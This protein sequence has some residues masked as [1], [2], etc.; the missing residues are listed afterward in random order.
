MV[1]RTLSPK[2]LDVDDL[3]FEKD[4]SNDLSYSRM[5]YQ[6]G[7]IH[8]HKVITG[9][10]GKQTFQKLSCRRV[11]T[12]SY[13]HFKSQRKSDLEPYGPGIVAYF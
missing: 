7:K 1:S 3:G 5:V 8:P 2:T 6:T 9:A 10:D 13:S 12:G 11:S 4:G